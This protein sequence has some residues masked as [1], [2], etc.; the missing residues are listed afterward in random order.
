MLQNISVKL[1]DQFL[2]LIYGYLFF[3]CLE[4]FFEEER[5]KNRDGK[6]PG[7]STS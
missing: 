4:K 6:S 1:I 5:D 7:V 2:Y 3:R